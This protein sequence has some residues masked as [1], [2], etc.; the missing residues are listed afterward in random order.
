VLSRRFFGHDQ[1]LTVRLDSGQTLRVRVGA[2]GGIRP[3]DRVVVG[4]RG[5]VLTFS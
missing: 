3:E 4:V 5:A 1:L 2:Y